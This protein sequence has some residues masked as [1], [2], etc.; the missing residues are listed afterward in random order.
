MFISR[1]PQGTG[2]ATICYVIKWFRAQ[3]GLTK[4]AVLLKFSRADLSQITQEKSCGLILANNIHAKMCVAFSLLRV[5]VYHCSLFLPTNDNLDQEWSKFW[6]VNGGMFVKK[7]LIPLFL[8][9]CCF[10]WQ[11]AFWWITLHCDSRRK[12]PGTIWC[13]LQVYLQER[14]WCINEGCSSVR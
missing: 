13:N 7:I 8:F 9:F 10:S 12:N 5:T 2:H 11:T 6:Q 1:T 14:R 3:F 4:F